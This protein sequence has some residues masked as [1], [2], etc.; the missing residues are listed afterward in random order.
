MPQLETRT[1]RK[2]KEKGGDTPR[3]VLIG[4][5]P[6]LQWSGVYIFTP[7]T[8]LVHYGHDSSFPKD[9]IQTSPY[10]GLLPYL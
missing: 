9:K 5:S 1:R 8:K 4:L 7:S 10:H 3:V 2:V 6:L